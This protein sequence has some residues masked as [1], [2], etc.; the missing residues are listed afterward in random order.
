MDMFTEVD[1]L[2]LNMSAGLGLADLTEHEKEILRDEFE[3][4]YEEV[5]G[6]K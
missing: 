1:N 2:L 6:Y 3:T 4:N 5:L